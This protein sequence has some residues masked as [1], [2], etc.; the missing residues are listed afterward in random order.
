MKPRRVA[1]TVFNTLLWSLGIAVLLQNIVLTAE[2][3]TL[4]SR[5]L[6]A[7][8]GTE[9]GGRLYTLSGI[10]A[11][12][13]LVALPM[14]R[15][16]S[17][18]M[19]IITFSPGCPA[20]LQNQEGWNKLASELRRRGEWRVIWVSRD[21]V[22]RTTDY[23]AGTGIPLSDVFA[24]PPYRTYAQLGL[25]VVPKMIVV[26]S[27]GVVE[28]VWTGALDSQQWNSLLSYVGL[29]QDFVSATAH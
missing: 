7:H 26:N 14:P 27:R 13:Q 3:R 28:K 9:V 6:G 12:G 5:L 25:Q 2:N 22:L 24:E 15:S 17:E 23:F 4:R 18:R 16:E 20:C 8:S 10:T 29:K 11:E 19:L 21:P 1:R